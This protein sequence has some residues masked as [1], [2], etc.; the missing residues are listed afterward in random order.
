MVLGSVD[1]AAGVPTL[2]FSVD[3]NRIIQQISWCDRSGSAQNL[4]LWIVPVDTTRADSHAH[5]WDRQ[6]PASSTL[7]TQMHSMELE[8]GEAIW[9]QGSV[10][11]LSVNVIGS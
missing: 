4:R 5:L 9:V 1:A 10:G 6:L 2:A 8:Y 11:S 3:R 7:L